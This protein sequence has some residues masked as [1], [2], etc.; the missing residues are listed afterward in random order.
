MEL[1]N[2]TVTLATK[3][4]KPLRRALNTTAD[5]ITA[6]L[7]AGQKGVRIINEMLDSTRFGMA[8]SNLQDDLES[9]AELEAIAGITP[10]QV[11]SI[12]KSRIATSMAV[13]ES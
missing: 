5:T 8:I 12:R 3:K 6:T 1:N 11:E 7:D 10:E 9:I 13:L 2:T 4:K